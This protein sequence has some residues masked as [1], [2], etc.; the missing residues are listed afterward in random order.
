MPTIMSCKSLVG[1]MLSF[2]QSE[3]SQCSDQQY[4]S[5][6]ELCHQGITVLYSDLRAHSWQTGVL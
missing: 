6:T 5:F 2:I 3:R 1:M 4:P